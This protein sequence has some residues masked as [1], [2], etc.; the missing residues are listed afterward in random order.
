MQQYLFTIEF[1]FSQSGIHFGRLQKSNKSKNDRRG[2]QSCQI[3]FGIVLVQI[4]D[5]SNNLSY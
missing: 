2:V 1:C 5:K 3:V 4:Q